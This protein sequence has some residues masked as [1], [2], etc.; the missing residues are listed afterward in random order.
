MIATRRGVI[1]EIGRLGAQ[2]SGLRAQARSSSMWSKGSPEPSSPSLATHISSS[3]NCKV[4]AR[5][6]GPGVHLVR[7]GDA[8]G[9]QV[10]ALA[11]SPSNRSI[12]EVHGATSASSTSRPAS[13]TTCG[14][15]PLR[16]AT[17]GTPQAMASISIRPN[18][19]RQRAVV[20]LGAHI[21]SIALRCSGTSSWATPVSTL[22]AAGMRGAERRQ[23]VFHRAAADE[24]RAPRLTDTVERLHQHVEPLGRHEPPEKPHDRRVVVPAEPRPH[25]RSCGGVRPE[26]THVDA[27]RNDATGPGRVRRLRGLR[28]V[29]RLAEGDPAR[30][31]AHHAAL[32]VAERRR[33]RLDDVLKRRR[34]DA[35]VRRARP[36]RP[37]RTRPRTAPPRCARHPTARRG[38]RAAAARSA[39]GAECVRA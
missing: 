26:A 8:A 32:E 22:H 3:K 10:A 25:R 36:T 2:G 39:A 31:T 24:Q 29:H 7:A 6:D 4:R 28:L 37:A 30:G 15:S 20:W 33:I 12:A 18:C 17:T 1:G 9:R 5:D 21:R 14:I 35:R 16:L 27:G 19:S 38:A 11:G 23:L 13:P 34:H